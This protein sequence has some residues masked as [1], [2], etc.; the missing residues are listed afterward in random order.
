MMSLNTHRD[1][2]KHIPNSPILKNNNELDSIVVNK[3]QIRKELRYFRGILSN[4][5]KSDDELR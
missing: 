5:I 1:I 3:R 2:S 4:S